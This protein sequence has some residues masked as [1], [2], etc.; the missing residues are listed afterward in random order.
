MP[1]TALNFLTGQKERRPV[2]GPLRM[3][4]VKYTKYSCDFSRAS[5]Y[6]KQPFYKCLLFKENQYYICDLNEEVM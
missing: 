4:R 6:K 5:R 1:L 3:G 2:R